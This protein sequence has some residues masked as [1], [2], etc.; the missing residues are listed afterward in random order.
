MKLFK[1]TPHHTLCYEFINA[2]TIAR[3]GGDPF[4][5]WVEFFG[6][7]MIDWIKFYAVSA[8]FQPCNGGGNVMKAP[9]INIDGISLVLEYATE[10]CYNA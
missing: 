8:I 7:V 4:Y 6:N 2:K 3:Q 10:G 5:L 1:G 9:L